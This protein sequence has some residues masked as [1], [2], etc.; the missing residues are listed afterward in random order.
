MMMMMTFD[1]WG[2]GVRGGYQLVNTIMIGNDRV[3]DLSI[4]M[5]KFSHPQRFFHQTIDKGVHQ[6]ALLI[7]EG[8]TN[9]E[10]HYCHNRI[11]L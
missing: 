3:E 4:L 9:G 7:E 2:R 5:L 8:F 1:F 10:R 11:L 6:R